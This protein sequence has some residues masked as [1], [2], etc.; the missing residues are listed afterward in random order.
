MKVKSLKR[1]N[2]I[3]VALIVLC[4]GF[5]LF[6]F[7]RPAVEPLVKKTFDPVKLLSSGGQKGNT[8]LI[9]S[10]QLETPIKSG[11]DAGSL[12][13]AAWLRPNTSKPDESG[14]T[15]LAG[16][17]FSYQVRSIFF[18]LNRVKTGD[19]VQIAWEGKIYDY[20]ITEIKEVQPSAVEIESQNFD[21]RLT[22]YTCTPI[23]SMANRLVVIAEPIDG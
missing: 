20:R 22:I 7:L 4:N 12:N 13:N 10:I 8:L 18:N 17:R 19:Q 15:V 14:N 5:I 6:G 23:W 9:P 3:L 21:E 11:Y 1:I 16:H 2:Y